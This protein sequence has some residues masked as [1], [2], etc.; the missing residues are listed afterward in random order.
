M[1]EEWRDIEGYEGL[2]Q[3]SNLGRVRSLN[4]RGHKGC[5][6]ILTPRLDGKGYEM[7][8]LYKEGKA[9]NTKVHR[10]VAQ[11]FIPNPNNYPQVNHKDENKI[12]NNVSNLEWCTVLY[13]NCYGTR[14]KR[15]SDKNKGE[16]NPMYGKPSINR[17]KV[18]CV[19]TG[20]IFDS[21]TEASKKYKCKPSHI[22]QNCKGEIKSCSKLSDGTK[23]IWEYY[24]EEI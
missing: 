21:I 17:K 10:L 20:E 16:G 4:C 3:V 8:A 24:K 23:L 15:V 9:R 13:N 19:T 22:I 6:G 7:V 5:I 12:N 1:N 18:K 2:Y 14:L 11:A